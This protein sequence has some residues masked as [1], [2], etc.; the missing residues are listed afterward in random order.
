MFVSIVI[1][2]GNLLLLALLIATLVVWLR[3]GK[4][5]RGGR[6]WLTLASALLLFVTFAPVNVWV[7]R[8]LEDRFP[9]PTSLPARVDGILVLGGIGQRSI[10][11]QR[12]T[13]AVTGA[14]ER[15]M[16]PAALAM[17][18]P[19]ARLVIS[20]VGED[21]SSLKDW[22]A[23]IGLER[24]RI[25]FETESH[26]TFENALFSH[27][28]LQ[29]KSGEVWLLVTSARHMPRAVG[30]FRKLGWPVVPYP[31]DYQTADLK[32][33][34]V[35]PDVAEDLAQLGPVFKEWAGLLAYFLMGHTDAL[36]PA[37]EAP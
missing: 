23:D 30:V 19:D 11:D 4:A 9:P 17:Q 13:L 1:R 14:A 32:Y 29:P 34:V 5:S 35:G 26:N 10:A 6:F 16:V 15:L 28:K 18:H 12:E 20:G 24:D 8:P 21:T 22:F 25:A 7:A 3:P 31:V 33:L 36:W 27:R 2:P 37:P